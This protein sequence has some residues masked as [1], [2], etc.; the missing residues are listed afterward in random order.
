MM[1]EET[2]TIPHSPNSSSSC[3]T[4][5][6]EE[7][8]SISLCEELIETDILQV[9]V[10]R[11][12]TIEV[13]QFTLFVCSL[14]TVE[15]ERIF[16]DQVCEY[17]QC[18]LPS[19]VRC[20]QDV[21]VRKFL[22]GDREV[23]CI[24]GGSKVDLSFKKDEIYLPFVVELKNRVNIT[25]TF[26]EGCNDVEL[27]NFPKAVRQFFRQTLVYALSAQAYSHRVQFGK[28]TSMT[29]A[30]FLP[31]LL[32]L[33]HLSPVEHLA[34]WAVR[35]ECF[36]TPQSIGGGIA[37]FLK[38]IE[39]FSN[40]ENICDE[41][42]SWIPM[43]N[44]LV[45]FENSARRAFLY[46]F[47]DSANIDVRKNFLQDFLEESDQQ[48]VEMCLQGDIIFKHISLLRDPEA[49][50]SI[51]ML[52]TVY[53]AEKNQQDQPFFRTPIIYTNDDVRM[54]AMRNVG[55]SLPHSSVCTVWHDSKKQ[56]MRD[57]CLSALAAA[58]QFCHNDIRPSNI[59]M[60][61]QVDDQDS[62]VFHLIDWDN[63]ARKVFIAK[64][65]DGR[66]PIIRCNV[67]RSNKLL[68]FTALQ[69][70]NVI[71]CIH[72]TTEKFNEE[73]SFSVPEGMYAIENHIKR[74]NYPCPEFL[75]WAS[76][77]SAD[78]VPFVTDLLVVGEHHSYASPSSTVYDQC[79]NVLK[80]AL[81][82]P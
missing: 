45:P 60:Q 67:R 49:A 40:N 61:T 58:K 62:V 55:I 31:N 65:V 82:V 13:E 42:L 11:V 38:Q 30:M 46:K 70:L 73:E 37:S 23:P 51:S 68:Y 12:R 53:R 43:S 76:S 9:P 44:C 69:L 72:H 54:V 7:S 59:T 25:R 33:I 56:F 57:V 5:A 36:D 81:G 20:E 66:Y 74:S 14:D 17:F 26:P 78:I 39:F 32:F 21:F 52:W 22:N 29:C 80:Q 18:N 71:F 48:T 35:V 3:P 16:Q 1:R 47:R 50:R 63:T 27:G 75:G 8:Y 64:E 6:T 79:V 4:S 15:S 2:K 24:C 34:K 77:A 10:S 19:D 41:P 28:A